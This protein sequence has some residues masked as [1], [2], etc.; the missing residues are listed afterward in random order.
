MTIDESKPG[1]RSGRV[2]RAGSGSTPAESVP[3]RPVQE[4]AALLGVPAA[5][6]APNVREGV[7]MLLRELERL[8]REGELKD[9]RIA[10]LERLADEDPLTPILNRRAFLRELSR[11]AGYGERYGAASSLLFF[12][13]N[14]MKRINDRYGHAAGDAALTHVAE[15]LVRNVRAS[16]VVGRLG[17]DEFAVLLMQVEEAMALRKGAE[18]ARLIGETPFVWQ[19]RTLTV[20]AACGAV[21]FEAGTEPH[22][23]L[24]AADRAM[25]ERKR[26]AP[27]AARE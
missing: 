2:Q 15:I 14:D 9:R 22:T 19:G 12:D 26:S 16:D 21:A 17:G 1:E 4:P 8:R 10:D 13:V 25:Y 24:E 27:G 6:L 23:I 20:T 3:V 7:E 18:L 5:E 11:M